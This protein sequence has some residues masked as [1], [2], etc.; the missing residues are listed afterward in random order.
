MQRCVEPRGWGIRG[1]CFHGGHRGHSKTSLAF[2]VIRY[3]A[4]PP[5]LSVKPQGQNYCL[6]LMKIFLPLLIMGSAPDE[7]NPGHASG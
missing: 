2:V 6:P 7:K 1:K 3:F 5:F 4:L